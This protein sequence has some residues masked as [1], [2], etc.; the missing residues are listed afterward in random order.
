[1]N[2]LLLT[3]S[4]GDSYT[5]VDFRF[6]D[7][8]PSPQYPIGN[9][10]LPGGTSSG[11]LNWVGQFLGNLNTS[12]T[13]SYDFAYNGAT[14]DRTIVAPYGPEVQCFVDQADAWIQNL[15]KGTDYCKWTAQNSLFSFWFGI[16]D[17]G[18]LYPDFSDGTNIMKD[19]TQQY[20]NQVVRLIDAGA[21]NLVFLTIPRN[22]S[23]SF[24][25]PFS[26]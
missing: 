1:L 10:L 24:P 22:S 26:S 11:G 25:D 12:V 5:K 3:N 13:V 6:D 16:N 8:K 15:Q 2:N 14:V 4:S 21:K 9:P 20:F 7:R 19:V 18:M 17:I 23:S